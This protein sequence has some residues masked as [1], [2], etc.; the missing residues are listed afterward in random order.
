MHIVVTH[1]VRWFGV[2]IRV[3]ASGQS[4]LQYCRH[5]NVVTKVMQMAATLQYICKPVVECWS[6]CAQGCGAQRQ[7]ERLWAVTG[8][9][10]CGRACSPSC[11]AEPA[12]GVPSSPRGRAGSRGG[13][14]FVAGGGRWAWQLP[15][16][17]NKRPCIPGHVLLPAPV[18]SSP[19]LGWL[20]GEQLPLRPLP[21][22]ASE[23]RPMGSDQR[24]SP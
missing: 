1:T 11:H 16:P 13:A 17:E 14:G 15:L 3:C 22:A 24:L 18:L 9:P 20:W 19:P 2:K 12:V 7:M 4:E 21:L 10:R 6:C 8:Q 23:A 5:T